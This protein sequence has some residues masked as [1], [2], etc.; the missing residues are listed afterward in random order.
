MRI[1]E[2]E[3]SEPVPEL[4]D[5]HVLA[6]LRPWI[7]VGSVGTLALSRVERYLR[8]REIGRL[9]RPGIFYD[10]TRYRPRSFFNEGRREVSIPNTIIRHAA[11][12]EG[13]DLLLVHLL[14]PHLFG[15]DFTETMVEVLKFF[16]VKRYSLIGGMY[17]MV[18]HTRPLLVSG[19]A[20]GAN[21]EDENRLLKVQPSNYEGP[22]TITYLISQEAQKMGIETRIFVVHLPQYF[23][24]D[25]D[26]TGTAR[27]ME[28]LCALYQLPGRLIEPQRGQEQY[29]KLQKMVDD[30]SGVAS[31]L[32]RLEERYDKEQSPEGP[33]PPPLSPGIEEFLRDLDDEFG[34]P[35]R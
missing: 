17:D 30:T 14:E 34:S 32:Q 3:L 31:L 20:N 29:E 13:P 12:E 4:K 26:F 21:V 27:L 28:I 22:T 6:V 35:N 25:E 7:D 5:P 11:R 10:F 8:A 18:P 9:A 33:P 19:V 1:G 16:G 15:E 23:Q 24:V 2:F